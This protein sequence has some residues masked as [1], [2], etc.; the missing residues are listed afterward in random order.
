M[1]PIAVFALRIASHTSSSDWKLSHLASMSSG[2]T[3]LVPLRRLVLSTA[4][5]MIAAA[6][7]RRRPPSGPLIFS[8]A[9]HSVSSVDSI[10]ASIARGVAIE[11]GL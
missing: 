4:A 7:S 1:P 2:V 9:I 10:R 8:Y 3:A 5:E 6:T 11:R